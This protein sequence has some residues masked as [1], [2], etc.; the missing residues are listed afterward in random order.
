MAGTK[1]S[2]TELS[3]VVDGVLKQFPGAKI[4][5]YVQRPLDTTEHVCQIRFQGCTITV[6]V[7]GRVAEMPKG[8]D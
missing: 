6:D 1:L 5:K 2:F 4:V 3:G 7:Y 8:K